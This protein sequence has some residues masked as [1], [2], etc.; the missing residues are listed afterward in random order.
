MVTNGVAAWL[1]LLS[2]GRPMGQEGRVIEVGEFGSN[3]GNL[4]MFAYAPSR[5]PVKGA[6]LIVVMHGCGQGAASFAMESGWI[7]LAEQIGAALVLPEQ[8][9]DNNQGRCFN[10][11][12]PGDVRRG[13]GEA[14]SV[15]Q[16]IR[17][18]LERY[19]SDPKR[20]FIVGLSAGGAMALALLAA[21]PSVFNAGAI[22]AG[23][24][25]GAAR[26]GVMALV[27]MRH[28]DQW[29][30]ATALAA[31]ARHAAP[32]SK[33]RI[34]PR[35]SLW[36]GDN[37]KVVDPANAEQIALQWR[38]LQGVAEDATS[39]TTPRPG[40]RRRAW[41]RGGRTAL[42]FWTIAGLGH[43]FP[44]DP[45]LPD[46]GRAGFGMVEA[47]ISATAHIARFWGLH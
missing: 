40:V 6:P 7:A 28:A 18:A 36:Q 42:E 21:Y 19:H 2:A 22:V 37:D 24:P 4:R 3:P 45:R 47:E 9:S 27:R 44:I 1:S 25:V 35:L 41:S 14:L 5:Q 11:Y 43:G 33:S 29:G 13:S 16:M 8:K 30:Q 12:R 31:A 23:M 38:T 39:D 26:S 34:W 17:S 32:P 15:R 10:W 46:G 20:I